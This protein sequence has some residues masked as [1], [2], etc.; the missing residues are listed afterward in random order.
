MP[1][2]EKKNPDN[3]KRKQNLGAV[4]SRYK[5]NTRCKDKK[6]TFMYIFLMQILKVRNYV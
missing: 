6:L 5:T 1:R 3:D 4:S 2:Q